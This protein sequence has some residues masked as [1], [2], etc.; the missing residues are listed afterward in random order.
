M[1]DKAGGFDENDEKLVGMLAKHIGAFMRQ[2]S[3]GNAAR[4]EYGEAEPLQ[5]LSTPED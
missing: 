4:E 1:M 2:L 5:P 3:E